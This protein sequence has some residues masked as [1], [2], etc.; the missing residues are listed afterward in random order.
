MSV[1]NFARSIFLE[2]IIPQYVREEYP[3]F[4]DFLREYY[5]YLDTKATSLVAVV[6]NDKGKNYSN[7]PSIISQVLDLDETSS[8]Y[9]EYIADPFGADFVIEVSKGKII[10]VR[11]TDYGAGYTPEHRTKLTITD[12]QGSGAS[13]E[14]VIIDN[15][16]QINY[17]VKQL[18]Y[19][20]DFDN[21][22]SILINFLRQE[23]IP[24]IPKTLYKSDEA[25]I[26]LTKFVKFIRQF[27]TK[28]GIEDSIK[29]LYRILFN[30][31][32]EFYYPKV[33]ML[34]VSDGRWSIDKVLG[35]KPSTTSDWDFSNFGSNQ[36]AVEAFVAY[37]TGHRFLV[38]DDGYTA[39][40]E[41]A[42]LGTEYIT[43]DP[44]YL[45]SLSG[46][47]GDPTTDVSN[48]DTVQD[49]PA[50]GSRTTIGAV[51]KNSL[52]Q[53]YYEENGRYSG[54]YGQLSSTKKIQDSFY[55][56][57]FSYELQSEE[58]ISNISGLLEEIVHP[59]GLKYFIRLNLEN[60]TSIDMSTG[61][62]DANI[63]EQSDLVIESSGSSY[64]YRHLGPT[65][66]SINKNKDT[67]DPPG[68]IEYRDQ[69]AL[70][71]T[72]ATGAVTLNH[73][74]ITTIDD[75]YNGY[76]L[77]IDDGD[78]EIWATITDYN[79]STQEAILDTTLAPAI[80]NPSYILTDLLRPSSNVT[81]TNFVLSN[82][83]QWKNFY[84]GAT[85][86]TPISSWKLY[87]VHGDAAGH[88]VK[89]D[90]YAIGSSGIL[91]TTTW[92][93]TAPSTNSTYFLYPDYRAG[94][95]S[96]IAATGFNHGYFT[97]HVN[98]IVLLN[99]GYDYIQPIITI[100]PPLGY[101]ESDVVI[102]GASAILGASGTIT[103][104]NITEPGRGYVITP[105]ITI[106]DGATGS[107][108]HTA[109]AYAQ[110]TQSTQTPWS[111][112]V[113]WS[114]KG[115]VIL[116]ITDMNATFRTA[117][118]EVDELLNGSVI[119]INLSDSGT[120]YIFPPNITFSGGG[121][122]NHAQAYASLGASGIVSS[123]TLTGLGNGYD[124]A[125]LISFSS[126]LPI[127]KEPV[128]Q[129]STGAHGLLWDYNIDTGHIYVVKHHSSPDFIPGTIRYVNSIDIEID[130]IDGNWNTEGFKFK[131]NGTEPTIITLVQ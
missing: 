107:T 31:E 85:S 84:T 10:A 21:E 80:S 57:D 58:S 117:K 28:A 53:F 74:F 13:V 6:V 120:G 71:S 26:E 4:V 73:Q 115:G 33:D 103:S 66:K 65:Y 128:Y 82:Y 24:K 55:Y 41:G 122:Q 102:A 64:I 1:T 116:H 11:V 61:N 56:Q 46:L 17:S 90:S 40:I 130:R 59:A 44:I 118:A 49:Y 112:T 94:S 81:D 60:S 79:G 114:E 34:R 5:K 78:K 104:I 12:S 88:Y 38:G 9:G 92:G 119:S 97:G 95:T 124:S 91:T 32:V 15:I 63:M 48:G 25:S 20:R 86:W 52:G 67:I 98:E 2:S 45:V 106:T 7:T 8:T 18:E 37:F 27:Y 35:I 89:V 121:T 50:T 69:L 70:G 23:Y 75:H 19:A 16:G 105:K 43:G 87:I 93:S 3:L 76:T 68:Y 54:D 123:V 108:G 77:I 14:P 36:A 83:D 51:T 96:F 109:I 126:A 39:I 111:E 131:N 29:F 72:G 101:N 30:A 113:Q 129:E 22:S 127:I 42:I 62:T 100:D 47:S 125:P 110:L 99:G